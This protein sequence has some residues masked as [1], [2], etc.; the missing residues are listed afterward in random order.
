MKKSC[1][2]LIFFLS[3]AFFFTACGGDGGGDGGNTNT[4]PVANAGHNMNALKN[5]LFV[6]DGSASSDADGDP[7]AFPETICISC[8]K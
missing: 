8:N 3:V 6:L 2:F 4:P 1:A 5:A 7:L